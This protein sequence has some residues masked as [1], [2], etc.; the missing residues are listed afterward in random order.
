MNRLQFY[1]S[2]EDDWILPTSRNKSYRKKSREQ[3]NTASPI[4]R[5]FGGDKI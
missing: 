2:D 3:R 5:A 4:L 1:D